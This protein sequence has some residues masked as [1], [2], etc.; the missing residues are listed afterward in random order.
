MNMKKTI[1]AGIV[2]WIVSAMF[3]WLTCAWLFNWVY[4]LPPNIWRTAE[5]MASGSSLLW[6]NLIGLVVALIFVG[7]YAN[8]HKA[9]SGEG[10]KKGMKYGFA[11]W[12]V[13]A[14]SGLAALPFYMTVATTVV[15]YWIISSLVINLINGAI[16]GVMYKEQ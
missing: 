4:K 10:A 3:G 16:V 7:V 5:E 8:L 13:G 15:V 12:L 6:T 11:V 2:V 14:V 9:L 1:S